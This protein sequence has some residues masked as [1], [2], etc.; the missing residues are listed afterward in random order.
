MRMITCFGRKVNDKFEKV[1]NIK[2]LSQ[3]DKTSSFLRECRFGLD[4]CCNMF[5]LTTSEVFVTANPKGEVGNN[6][7]V[8]SHFAIKVMMFCVFGHKTT[9]SEIRRKL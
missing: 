8:V 4:I 6:L 9:S 3:C 1:Q 7:E 5:L 2:F